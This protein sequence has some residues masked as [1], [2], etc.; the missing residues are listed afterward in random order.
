ML[1]PSATV[2]ILGL[3]TLLSLFIVMKFVMGVREELAMK[4]EE[5]VAW[6]WMYA[7]G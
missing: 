4:K 3:V 2:L 6:G 1:D 5:A 7:P